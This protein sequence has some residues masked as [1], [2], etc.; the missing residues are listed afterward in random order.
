MWMFKVN[1]R[2]YPKMVEAISDRHNMYNKQRELVFAREK[3]GRAFVI[4]PEQKL[5]AGRIE[6]DPAALQKTYDLGREAA[7]KHLNEL[8]MFIE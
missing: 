4:C 2:K 5:P 8:K 3:E 6:H 1:L 7:E